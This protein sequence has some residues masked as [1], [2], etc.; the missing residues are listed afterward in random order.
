MENPASASDDYADLYRQ[1][2]THYAAQALWYMR[3]LEDPTPEDALAV[4]R[5]LRIEGDLRARYL[6]EKIE[7]ACRAAH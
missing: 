2:F 6:A 5:S 7:Q 1:A 4:A 3:R